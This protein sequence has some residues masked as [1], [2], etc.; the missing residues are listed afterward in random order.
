MKL[1]ELPEYCD[2]HNCANCN[3]NLVCYRYF[4]NFSPMSFKDFIKDL[5]KEIKEDD[6]K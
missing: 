6:E 2:N 4:N 3:Y 5:D 1:K